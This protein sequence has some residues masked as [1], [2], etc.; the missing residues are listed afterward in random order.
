ME[1]PEWKEKYATVK[2]R[3]ADQENLQREV[4][5]WIKGQTYAELL[6]VCERCGVPISKIM[7]M[8]DIFDDP[9]YAARNDIVTLPNNEGVPVKM[10]GVFP[11]LTE[12]PG[13]VKWA[14]PQLGS[15]NKEIYGS[16]L[17]YSDEQLAELK[18]KGII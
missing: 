3:L 13:Q 18:E 11:V 8:K 9:Q 10:P 4:T 7:S 16:L 12:T 6:A 2:E 15:S 17:G 1:R 5:A 14:G